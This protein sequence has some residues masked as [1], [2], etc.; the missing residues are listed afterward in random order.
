[1]IGG[2]MILIVTCIV[3]IGVLLLNIKAVSSNSYKLLRGVCLFLFAFTLLRYF[4]LIVYGDSP[5]YDQMVELRYF[6]LASSIGLTLTTASAIWYIT[7]LYREK[8]NYG[9]YLLFFTPWIL[10][11]SYV[12][13]TQPTRIVQG[14]SFG[15]VLELIPPYF[16]YLSIAQSSFIILMITLC[17][18]GM[19]KYKHAQ[20]RVQL[21]IIILAQIAL[22][23]DGLTYFLPI[24]HTFN[25]FTVS[26]VLGFL[27]VWYAFSNKA[28]A[29]N[30]IGHKKR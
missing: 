20:L 12:I 24:R 22:V 18:I 8:I 7:P 5:S 19:I 10:F 15:Y 11:Y 1:M 26:E 14:K 21:F 16:K 6:Y 4:T 9:L 25:P 29:H 27:A 2:Y 28:I 23:L 30:K 17:I 3:A 13:I